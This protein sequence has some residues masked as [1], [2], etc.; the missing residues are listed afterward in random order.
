VRRGWGKV[1]GWIDEKGFPAKKI[2][3]VWQSDTN[4]IDRWFRE[5]IS[6][7]ERSAP[8]KQAAFDG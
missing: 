7:E 2:D 5:T 3:G 4:L 1:K 8:R 6:P